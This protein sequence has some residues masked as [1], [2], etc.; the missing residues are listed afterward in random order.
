MQRSGLPVYHY[1]NYVELF[2][3]KASL[4]LEIV[5]FSLDEVILF[6]QYVS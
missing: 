5:S 1:N 6:L 2:S 4:Y 3:L